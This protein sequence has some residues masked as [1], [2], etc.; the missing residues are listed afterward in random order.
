MGR[1]L[2]CLAAVRPDAVDLP[3]PFA[4]RGEGEPFPRW[5]P[6]RRIVGSRAE[7]E[8]TDVRGAARRRNDPYVRLLAVLSHVPFR[9]DVGHPLSVRAHGDLRQALEGEDILDRHRAAFLG[10]QSGGEDEGENGTR[11]ENPG[12]GEGDVAHGTPL[13]LEKHRYSSPLIP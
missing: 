6:D 10:E 5:V 1:H 12:A 8:L 13:T 7:G 4:V 11:G 2:P 3:H 9:D